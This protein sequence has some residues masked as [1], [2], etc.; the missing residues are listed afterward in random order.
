VVV[1]VVAL[2]FVANHGVHAE[3]DA[4]DGQLAVVLFLHESG[5]VHDFE[6]G[7]GCLSPLVVVLAVENE[8]VVAGNEH[9]VD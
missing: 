1:Y 5:L 8:V 2:A 9:S 3:A 4:E 6:D 7:F